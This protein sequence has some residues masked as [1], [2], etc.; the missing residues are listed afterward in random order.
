[1]PNPFLAD[2]DP[3]QAKLDPL[4]GIPSMINNRQRV[5]LYNLGRQVTGKGCVVEVGSWLGCSCAHVALGL[6]DAEST[7]VVHC[8]DRFCPNEAEVQKAA[9][10]GLELTAGQDTTPVF[11]S[12]VLPIYPHVTPHRTEVL[13]I[14]WNGGPIELYIDDASKQPHVFRYMLHQIGPSLIPGVS[15]LALLDYSFYRKLPAGTRS[16]REKQYQK[17]AMERLSDHFTLLHEHHPKDTGAYFRYEK[18]IDFSQLDNLLP[19]FTPPAH[20]SAFRKLNRL[21]SALARRLGRAA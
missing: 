14:Q 18:P 5:I 15:V 16:W 1:M 20:V 8:F 6:A 10:Q 7:A 12:H 3:L 11:S 21:K 17:N 13:D 4:F 9:I 2:D 19:R